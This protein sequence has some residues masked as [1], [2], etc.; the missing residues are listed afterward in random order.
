MIR[1]EMAF[2][3]PAFLLQGQFAEDLSEM[4]SQ[5]P[6]QRLPA[7]LGNEHNMIFALPLGVA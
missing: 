1:H 6:V 7:A 5:F 2:F 3:N 4:P